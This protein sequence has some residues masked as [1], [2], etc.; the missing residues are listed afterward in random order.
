MTTP[1]SGPELPLQTPPGPSRVLSLDEVRGQPLRFISDLVAEYGDVVQYASGGWNAVLI[2]RPEHIKHVLSDAFHNYCKEG[3]PDLM[4][5]RPMLG[6][7][8]LTSDGED[9]ERQRTLL[10]PMFHLR[11][12]E[13]FAEC[14]TDAGDAMLKRWEVPSPG[15]RVDMASEATELTLRIAAKAL[16]GH[17]MGDETDNFTR[18]MD[19]LNECMGQPGM[20]STRYQAFAAALEV[21]RFTVHRA[22]LE[23]LA[24]DTAGQNDLLALLVANIRA[25]GQD[26]VLT[27]KDLMDQVLTLL[28]AGHETT[29]KSLCWT[30]YL[31]SQHPEAE[32]RVVSEA[33]LFPLGEPPRVGDLARFPYTWNVLQESMRL[34]PPIWLMSRKAIQDDAIGCYRIPAGTLVVFSPYLL[35][36]RADLW[37]APD[38]FRPERFAAVAGGSAVPYAYLPFG[39]GQRQCIG[40]Q[41]GI[42]ELRLLLPMLL[43]RFRIEVEPGHEVFPEALVTL[44]PRGGLPM[45]VRARAASVGES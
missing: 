24:G 32:A 2:N 8:L 25:H 34:Y 12:V 10:N 28:L 27:S 40:R 36:R 22:V 17:E 4:M 11:R 6:H 18:A 7:G 20:A 39:G 35:H 23:R 44:R 42:L 14:M 41:F 43:Q 38:T 30:L 1:P 15:V 33:Q 9:W 3:T 26:N 5:L 21:V 19:T 13:R 16:F 37:P 45:R 31:L 29:A